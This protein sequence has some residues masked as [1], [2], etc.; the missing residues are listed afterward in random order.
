MQ[1]IF[2]ESQQRFGTEKI[3]IILAENVIHVKKRE[4]EVFAGTCFGE[5]SRK[6]K[7]DYKKRQQ[8]W[9]KNLLSLNFTASWQF[10]E[11]R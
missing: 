2:D 5:Y 4:P 9:R 3:R 6:R 11:R 7:K 8:H 10:V 1:Q